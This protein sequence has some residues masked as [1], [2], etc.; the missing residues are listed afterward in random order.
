MQ[1]E[2]PATVAY[3]FGILRNGELCRAYLVCMHIVSY[4]V[5]VYDYLKPTMNYIACMPHAM[6][7]ILY[8]SCNHMYII[9]I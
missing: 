4:Y 3:S 2:E 5:D 1:M 8:V 7:Y 9:Y 6:K